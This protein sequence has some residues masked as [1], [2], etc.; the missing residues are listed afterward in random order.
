MQRRSSWRG[1][2]QTVPRSDLAV[3]L[4]A[5]L[6]ALAAQLFGQI[7]TSGRFSAWLWRPSTL[8]P[9]A[10]LRSRAPQLVDQ[11]RLLELADGTENLPDQHRCR[12]FIKKRIGLVGCDQF[13]AACLQHFEPNFLHD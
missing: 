3:R 13:D 8:T 1:R 5:A 2:A 9:V 4:L 10:R 6:R 12:A 7:T 11:H